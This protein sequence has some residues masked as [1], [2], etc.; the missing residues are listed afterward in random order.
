MSG[1]NFT[2]H[3]YNVLCIELNADDELRDVWRAN[4]AMAIHDAILG[5]PRLGEDGEI[6]Q[7]PLNPIAD[8]DEIA[9]LVLERIFPPYD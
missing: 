4:I 5:M 1:L 3:A 6:V 9:E 7:V 2:K 8:R